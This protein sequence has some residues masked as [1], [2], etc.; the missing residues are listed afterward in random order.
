MTK[1]NL[2]N[3]A[4]LLLALC[5]ALGGLLGVQASLSREEAM[6]LQGGGMVEFLVQSEPAHSEEIS[7]TQPPRALLTQDELTLVVQGLE[8]GAEPYPHEPGQ[9]HLSMTEALR[10]GRSWLEDFFMPHLGMTDFS[11]DERRTSC[12]LWTAQER[13]PLLSYWAVTFS[14]KNLE[15]EL[16]LNA[17]SGQILSAQVRC[18]FPSE[19]PDTQTLIAFLNDY[20]E[21]FGLEGQYTLVDSGSENGAAS[22]QAMYQ[23]IGSQNIF[24]AMK[25]SSIAVATSGPEASG[26]A[27]GDTDSDADSG[28]IIELLSIRLYLTSQPAE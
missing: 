22:G 23:R 5:I 2:I 6:L 19:Q 11:L 16:I 9:N 27:S 10:Y 8:S 20:A 14:T 1:N 15:T 4:G 17:V 18:V 12:Y 24:A 21:S 28:N 3:L 26:D 7:V 25:A 13:E